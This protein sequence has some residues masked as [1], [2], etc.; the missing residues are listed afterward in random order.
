MATGFF[1]PGIKTT[2][3]NETT[4]F[5]PRSYRWVNTQLPNEELAFYAE[6]EL[7]DGFIMLASA[8]HGGG[9]N[10]TADQEWL[11]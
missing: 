9:G 4:I 3:A 1:A 5:I 7:A 6:L 2:R 11:F 10:T 8:Y